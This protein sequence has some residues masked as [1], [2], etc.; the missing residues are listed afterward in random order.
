[1]KE[2]TLI[3]K[4]ENKFNEYILRTE[5]NEEIKLYAI[6][7]MEAVSPDFDSGKFAKF[8]GK[9]VKASGLF[10]GSALWDAYLEEIK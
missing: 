10:D 3:G 7:P 4:V 9:K 2:S 8:I 6:R 5:K 1:M